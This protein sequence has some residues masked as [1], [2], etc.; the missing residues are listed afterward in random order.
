MGNLLKQQKIRKTNHLKELSRSKRDGF[1]FINMNKKIFII[2]F[3]FSVPFFSI[4]QNKDLD[5]FVTNSLKNNP[6]IAEIQ[7]LILS[8][9]LDSQLI[10]AGNKIG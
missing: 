2:F 6:K 4:S 5:Y 10:F 1:C 7:N 3:L 9:S 8:N